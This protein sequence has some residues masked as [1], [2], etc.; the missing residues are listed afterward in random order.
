MATVVTYVPV[1]PW[2]PRDT[3]FQVSV[4]ATA[5]SASGAEIE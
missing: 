4:I 2:A 1:A 3:D 5:P